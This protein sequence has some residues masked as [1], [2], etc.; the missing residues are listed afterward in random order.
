MLLIATAG[1]AGALFGT[2]MSGPAGK[3]AT[4]TDGHLKPGTNKPTNATA[5]PATTTP[6]AAL[7]TKTLAAE[8][9]TESSLGPVPNPEL[10]AP[11]PN[12]PLPI[13]GKDGLEPW[14]AYARPFH[15]PANQPRIALVIDSMGLN[16][17][18]TNTAIERLPP[19]VTVAFSPYA[20]HLQSWVAE[21]RAYGHE[22]LLQLPM[23]PIGYPANDPGPHALLTS[24][25]AKQNLARLD[26]LLGRF[27]GYVGVTDYRGGAFMA[28]AAS[29]MPVLKAL[30]SRGLMAL[31]GRMAPHSKAAPL[32]RKIGLP[33]AVNDDVIDLNPS[34]SA[35][36]AELAKLESTARQTG[37]ATGVG[38]PYPVTVNTIAT[39]AA[40]LPKAGIVLA[41]VSALADATGR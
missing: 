23:Q 2:R 8:A 12:G 11:S 15:D 14:Q 1:L 35:I 4:R 21:A 24:L 10:I 16:K 3:P 32:A 27:T 26:W 9:S 36:Q 20:S 33:V 37:S 34:R 40:T 39:W 5:A 29:L 31:D 17:R 6:A 22:V 18:E 38:L 30:K 7:G 19:E 28:A 25:S 41:P 13:I